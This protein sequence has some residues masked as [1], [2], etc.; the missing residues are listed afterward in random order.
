MGERT[1]LAKSWKAHL[2]K[3]GVSIKFKQHQQNLV[4]DD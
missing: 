2:Q 1:L 3:I 4:L